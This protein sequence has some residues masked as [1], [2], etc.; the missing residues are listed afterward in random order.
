MATQP[1]PAAAPNASAA[2]AAASASAPAPSAARAGLRGRLS[3]AARLQLA[4]AWQSYGTAAYAAAAVT[5]VYLL[6][7]FMYGMTSTF[8][9]VNEKLAEYGL[10]ALSLALVL[11]GALYVR[12]RLAVSPAA[13]Y[14]QA[15]VK[16][17]THPGVLEVMGAPLVGSPVRAYVVTGGGVYLSKKLRI[18]L[19]ARRI[20]MMFPLSGS[21]RKG[22]VSLEAKRKKVG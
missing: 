11:L 3:Q 8:I 15:L 21:E 4:A 18:K 7:R 17:N 9:S 16:L 1:R 2:P 14:R 13:V 6:W 19:R 10:M 20:Q 5:A 12:W 22:L